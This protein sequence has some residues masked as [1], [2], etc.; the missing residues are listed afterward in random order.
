MSTTL[1]IM[2]A[3]MGSRYGGDK[4]VDGLGPHNEILVD[5]TIHDA[6][7]AGFDRVVFVIRRSMEQRFHDLIGDRISRKCEVRYAFQEYDS[8]PEGFVPP[9]DRVKPYGTVHAVLCARDVIDGPF[10]VVNADDYY[11]KDAF[12]TIAAAL[13]RMEGKQ[14]CMVAYDLGNTLSENGTVTRGVCHVDANGLLEGVRETYKLGRDGQGLIRDFAGD[15]PSDPL[16]ENTPVS[17]NFWGLT[18]WFF[19]AAERYFRAFLQDGT[20]D[21][22]KAEFVL[23]TLIDT[24]MRQEHLPVEVLHTHAKWFGVTYR[25]DK[26]QVQAAL[27]EKHRSGEYPDQL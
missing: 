27:L 14:A 2:A 21:P 8:L 12:A 18:P 25:E 6:L 7:N 23:P 10:A 9:A 26:P 11:G 17:M 15:A 5:Y 19:P 20:R 13:Q 1:L 24:L 3:G 16:P 22:L 4:Q